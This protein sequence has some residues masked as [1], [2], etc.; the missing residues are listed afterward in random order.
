MQLFT[1]GTTSQCADYIK[2]SSHSDQQCCQQNCSKL[3]ILCT[4]YL[5]NGCMEIKNF[6]F[7]FFFLMLLNLAL[8]SFVCHRL[9]RGATSLDA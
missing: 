5:K 7:F 1:F 8:I 6:F 3:R 9:N 2:I 4:P